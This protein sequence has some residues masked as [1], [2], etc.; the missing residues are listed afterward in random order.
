MILNVFYCN[1]ERDTTE[2]VCLLFLVKKAVKAALGYM[3]FD[4]DSEISLTFCSDDH[5]KELNAKYRDRDAVTDVL[6]FPLN[7]FRNGDEPSFDD[8]CELGDI[9]IN[10]TR[11]REQAEEYGHS[12][13]REVAFLAV[14]STLHL[15]GLDHEASEEEDK[16]VCELQDAI[17]KEIGLE[18]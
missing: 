2:T 7:D 1:K 11:A 9:V 16:F 5:I 8:V 13:E 4:F 18:R 3:N 17:M 15:L 10:L 12:Y 6:S 14:H